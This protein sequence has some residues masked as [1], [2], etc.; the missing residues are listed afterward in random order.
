MSKVF[1]DGQ[2]RGSALIVSLVILLMVS[3]LGLSA[4]RASIFSTKV[5]TGV[6]AD[7]M[8]FD[9]AESA[10]SLTFQ[11]LEELT[12][13]Q[14][15]TAV[16]N[17]KSMQACVNSDGILKNEACAE[18]DHMDSRQLLRAGSYITHL[19]NRCRMVSGSDIE[20]YRDYV[21]DVLGES[22]MPSYDIEDNHL[23]E[24][25]KFGLDCIEI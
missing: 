19:K 2:Q 9:A 21:I 12:N 13:K 24:A 15:S 10:I 23:Q 25:L 5:S 1:T 4:M 8:T 20:S 17:G 11:K 6:Q 3:V 14:L 22:E 16:L 7:T 18:S